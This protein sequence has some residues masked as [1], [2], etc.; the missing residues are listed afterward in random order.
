[1]KNPQKPVVAIII[2]SLC[3]LL[4]SSFTMADKEESDLSEKITLLDKR[5]VDLEKRVDALETKSHRHPELSLN[6][7][8]LEERIGRLEK[9]LEWRIVPLNK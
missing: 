6:K 4:L 7:S 1:M 8:D 9:Q 3:I 2:A 5:L